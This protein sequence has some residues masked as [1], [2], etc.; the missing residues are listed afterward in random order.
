MYE[1]FHTV[2]YVLQLAKQ[3]R[4]QEGRIQAFLE[5]QFRWIYSGAKNVILN[6]TIG[7]ILAKI[8]LRKNCNLFDII[9]NWM[10]MNCE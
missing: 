5:S 6:L 4:A 2:G 1:Q 3:N 7:K 9:R 8:I 10:I